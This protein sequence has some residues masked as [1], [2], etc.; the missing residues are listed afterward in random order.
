MTGAAEKPAGRD[1]GETERGPWKTTFAV[2]F[3]AQWLSI[4]GFSFVLPFLPFYLREIGVTDERLV[5][6]WVGI[7]TFAAAAVMAFFSP[8]WGWLADRYGRKIMVE[9]AMF[10][11]GIL[12]IATGLVTNVHQLLV[13]RLLS[14]A[15]T[16]TISASLSLVSAVVPPKRLGFCLGLMQTAVFL[17]MTLGPWFGG[18]LADTVGYRATFITGGGILLAGGFL[19]LF[20]AKERFVRP[21]RETLRR[22]GSLWRLFRYPGF[23]TV[24]ALFF[25]FHGSFHLAIPL[26]PLFIEEVGRLTENV[27]STTGLLLAVSGGASALAAGGIGWLSDR[28]GHGRILTLC[29]LLSGIFWFLHGTAE[30]IPQL[31]AVRLLFGLAA[32]GIIPAMNALVGRIVP[33]DSYGKAYGVTASLTCLGMAFGPL[34]GGYL[35]SWLGYRWPFFVVSFVVLACAVPIALRLRGVLRAGTRPAA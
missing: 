23:G 15:M 12:S 27:A 32:G 25:L 21:A 29:L 11:G 4:L 26:L 22:G 3:A 24:V 35:A 2:L 10:G 30:S 28:L 20:G 33:R 9:R 17:G 14:G 7:L 8:L 5:P 19:V 31:F 6:V 18:L 34:A 1:E 16:G 13:L